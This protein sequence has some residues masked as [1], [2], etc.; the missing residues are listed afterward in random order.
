MD[1]NYTP[2]F[3]KKLMEADLDYEESAYFAHCQTCIPSQVPK[4]QSP[5]EFGSYC[6]S[7]VP[8][9]VD[10]IKI[11]VLVLWCKHCGKR[12][13]DSRHLKHAF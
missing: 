11:S 8:V 12:V 7:A 2:E 13:W 1:I 5:E 3:I 4:G 6:V 10:G 9:V